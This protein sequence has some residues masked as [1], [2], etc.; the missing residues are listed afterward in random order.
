[1]KRTDI[2]DVIII[3]AGVVGAC[4]ARF[5]SR[6]KLNIALVEKE[7][8]VGFGTSK[9]NSGVI[10]AG[11]HD[12]P[13]TLKANLCV[14]GNSM[15]DKLCE[16]LNV[17]FKRCGALVV[18]LENKELKILEKL[19][20]QGEKNKVPGLK[21]I[22][23]DDLFQIEPNLT[24]RVKAALYSPT[25]GVVSPYELTMA[26]A[27]NA[28]QNGV[29][30]LLDT[31]VKDVTFQ[32]NGAKVVKTQKGV[33]FTKYLVNAAGLFADE[34]ARMTGDNGF[35]IVPRKGEE[36]IL[37]KK[38]EELVKHVIFPIPQRQ[39]KGVLI[40]PTVDGNIMIG[41]T[42]Q[43]IDDK[44][45]LN[46]TGKGLQMILEKV[47]KIV[48]AINDRDIIAS[49]A[50]LRA[51][52]E[53]GDFII[54]PS[55][56]IRGFI[57]IAG[58]DSPGLTAAPAIAMMV[59]EIL[60][61]E[62]LKLVQ[63]DSYQ[64]SYRWIKFRELSPEQKEEL[65]KKDKRYGNVVCRCENVTEGE[66]VDAIKRGARTLD[67]IKFRTRAGMGRCQ[68]GFCTPKIMR[69]MMN[70]LNIPLEKIT[71]RGRGSNILWG[72]TK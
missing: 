17:P 48:P 43:V 13:G 27:E 38:R 58:I 72:K 39:T 70:E 42:S 9:A 2:F 67:G 63:K 10:H 53:G 3:G 71:K 34:I 64:P 44:F 8:E 12:R 18:A 24:R 35:T 20:A 46:T 40:I 61:G 16:E 50:G 41:P 57:N 66:I 7:A 30:I 15:F 25:V 1:M 11:F 6:Y 29:R 49:F 65:I 28:R 55:A 69:I 21:I 31:E 54:Q 23:D 26:L 68:G 56:K 47:R 52:S 62:G 36:Y 51:S 60:K 32:D 59:A 45:D 5:L 14:T 22:R 37:D 33:L 19:K 4:I